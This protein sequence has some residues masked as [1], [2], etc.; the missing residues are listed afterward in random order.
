MWCG[1]WLRGDCTEDAGTRAGLVIQPRTASPARPPAST[2]RGCHHHHHLHG[3]IVA[4]PG[5]SVLV[6]L[7]SVRRQGCTEQYQT[8]ALYKYNG[9]S[10][11]DW[12]ICPRAGSVVTLGMSDGWSRPPGE[13][14][15]FL[16]RVPTS[17][18]SLAPAAVPPSCCSTPPRPEINI[19]PRPGRRRSR[20]ES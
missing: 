8:L 10:F 7:G 11:A 20:G 6:I 19:P 3:G 15:A 9:S 2:S 17:L 4:T 14:G 5:Y 18:L 16:G 13:L 12:E 1:G